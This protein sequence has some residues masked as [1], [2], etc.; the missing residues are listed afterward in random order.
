MLD[1]LSHFSLH[2]VKFISR[3]A[4]K[5]YLCRLTKIYLKCPKFF[6]A[7][8]ANVQNILMKKKTRYCLTLSYQ[9]FKC[10][11]YFFIFQNVYAIGISHVKHFVLVQP[12]S[13]PSLNE[14]TDYAPGRLPSVL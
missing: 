13:S 12:L 8:R 14:T 6:K 10:F 5:Y 9:Q 2:L 4:R 3:A 1:M 11:V 7:F